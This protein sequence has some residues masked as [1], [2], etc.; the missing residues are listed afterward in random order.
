MGNR[1]SPMLEIGVNSPLQV[2]GVHFRWL[3]A[4]TECWPS[5]RS[6]L[7]WIGDGGE[8]CLSVLLS[9]TLDFRRRSTVADVTTGR[10][11][12]GAWVGWEVGMDGVR[13]DAWAAGV[14]L[15]CPCWAE[16]PLVMSEVVKLRYPGQHES[17]GKAHERL[18]VR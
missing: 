5:A 17:S 10:G 12:S 14:Q 1:H 13:R 6:S 9:A 7:S 4:V 11:G 2:G 15:D 16:N 8:C 3:V 18:V